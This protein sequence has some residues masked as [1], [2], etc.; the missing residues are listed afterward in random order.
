GGRR[1]LGVVVGVA[2]ESDLPPERLAE[3]LE[4]IE[5][6][7]TPEL[8][9]LGLWVA[10]RYCS[11]PPRGL[12][13]VLPPGSGTGRKPKPMRALTERTAA[14]RPEGA[15][16]L[17]PAREGP[18]LGARQRAVL[19]RLDADGGELS[20]PRIRELTGADS[21]VLARLAERG[22]IERRTREVRRAP[23]IDTVGA[24]AA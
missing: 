15:A 5:A 20:G 18:R 1:M 19:E 22:L 6:G 2:A 4:A 7:A 3:P 13:L 16:A 10:D 11:T 12:A 8:V 14:I 21:V 23:R 9:R 24:V 17:D